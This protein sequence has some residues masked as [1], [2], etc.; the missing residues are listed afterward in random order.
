M[1][2]KT[3]GLHTFQS[4][5]AHFVRVTHLN[6]GQL[7]TVSKRSDMRRGRALLSISIRR[8][9]LASAVT[10]A[11]TALLTTACCCTLSITTRRRVSLYATLALASSSLR[12]HR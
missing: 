4:G 9:L 1:K 11:A 6:S 10:A 2:S 5:L 8:Q 3:F 12:R 7:Q